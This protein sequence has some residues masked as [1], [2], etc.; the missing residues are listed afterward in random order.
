[1]RTSMCVVAGMLGGCADEGERTRITTPSD[2]AALATYLLDGDGTWRPVGPGGSAE[3]EL[4]DRAGYAHACRE[5][6]PASGEL[7]VRFEGWLVGRHETL[8][9]RRCPDGTVRLAG[10]VSQ[11]DL[12]KIFVGE[13]RV[14]ARDGAYSIEVENVANQ[15]VVAVV[16]DGD[17]VRALIARGVELRADRRLDL[18]AAGRGVRLAAVTL[19]LDGAADGALGY[20]GV[21]LARGTTVGF[22]LGAPEAPARALLLPAHALADGDRLLVGAVAHDASTGMFRSAQ[23]VLS[24]EDARGA[25]AVEVPGPAEVE[26]MGGRARWTGAW[27]GV[28]AEAWSPA[29][30]GLAHVR[31]VASA[32]ALDVDPTL[33]LPD[34]ADMAGW[35]PGWGGFSPG[36]EVMW[37]VA[38]WTGARDGDH[39]QVRASGTTRW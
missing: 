14:T 19:T 35:D 28:E 24:P 27:D 6:H 10:S 23:R 8:T 2:P 30:A 20:G 25:I 31:I 33:A 38:A 16:H 22:N 5:W 15:E 3:I 12:S 17:D 37:S 7:A 9:P 32:A 4:G 34:P 29:G 39:A 21:A 13:R 26:V 18:D 36:A 1:M 11:G